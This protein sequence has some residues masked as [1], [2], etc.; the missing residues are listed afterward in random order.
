MEPLR[1]DDP[2]H[3]GPY[4]LIGRLEAALDDVPAV[5][6]RYLAR[7]VGGD[8]TVEV[9][10]PLGQFDDDPAYGARFRAEAEQACR[11][12]G[13]VGWPAPATEVSAERERPVWRAR[14][15]RPGLPLPE[16]L[17]A[18]G[19][20]LPERTVRALGAAVA[21][22][23]A[24]LHTAGLAHAGLTPWAVLVGDRPRITGFGAV[25]AVAPDGQDRSGLPG[26]VAECTAPEQLTG[27]RPRPPGDV[28]ALG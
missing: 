5:E 1:Y 14:P 24:Q 23:L 12:A 13:R 18:Y 26:L 6:R 25:R 21:E 22:A 3:V 28:Y 11:L 19:G 27:G 2:R 10:T 7:P 4:V 16:A 17:V 8:R 15:Y 9:T 20:P